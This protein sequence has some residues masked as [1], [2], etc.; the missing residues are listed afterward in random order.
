MIDELDSKQ[1]E[2]SN[3]G[4]KIE[5]MKTTTYIVTVN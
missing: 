5:Q 3:G 4:P 1:A 2:A